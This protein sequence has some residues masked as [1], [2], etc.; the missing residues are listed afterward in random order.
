MSHADDHATPAQMRQKLLELV[1]DG[2]VRLRSAPRPSPHRAG[3][4]LS[5]AQEAMWLTEQAAPGTLVNV[6]AC[7]LTFQGLL[8]E[9]VLQEAWQSVVLRHDILRTR[10][11]R[12]TGLPVPTIVPGVPSIER[13]ECIA[14]GHASGVADTFAR[15]PIDISR[16][17][18]LK[19][20][21][22]RCGQQH[23]LALACHHIALDGWSQ[24]IVLRELATE[25]DAAIEGRRAALARPM[26]FSGW[27]AS[28]LDRTA[29]GAAAE[30]LDYWM[31]QLSDVEPLALPLDSTRP[32]TGRYE[33]NCIR[34]AIADPLAAGVRRFAV[35]TSMSLFCVL[36]AAYQL[37]LNRLT[38]QRDIVVGTATALRLDGETE[39]VVGPLVNTLAIRV[40]VDPRQ[41][42]RA[43]AR[44][45]DATMR[46]AMRHRDVP[47]ETVVR[48]L[49]PERG[50]SPFPI[51]QTM[52][53]LQ[54]FPPPS[55]V[56]AGLAASYRRI[57][58]PT[59]R[60]PFAVR[61]EQTGARLEMVLEHDPAS[62]S[63]QRAAWMSQAYLALLESGLREPDRPAA[64][65]SLVATATQ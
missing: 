48:H 26:Q 46:A 58:L 43:L 23:T 24:T 5:P 14:G 4:Q 29:H 42:F 7:E 61:F 38:R 3:V 17:G 27:A 54:N 2:Q 62:L 10:Y 53:V 63:D 11:D 1:L 13:L 36:L 18:P 30:S 50:A 25:Y 47:F 32:A 59:A 45:V 51:Y 39:Q 34:L 31:H 12:V 57:D 64:Q 65:L 33:G 6:L 41:G 15:T 49:H 19:A 22:I 44:Q 16:G 60:F 56:V 8:D 52:F 28:W 55:F 40:M 21:L 35:D 37:L 20:G 9:R